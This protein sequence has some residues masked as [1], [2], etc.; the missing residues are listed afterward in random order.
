MWLI[1]KKE[2]LLNLLSF[3]FAT[4]FILCVILIP[5]SVHISIKH[6]EERRSIYSSER[7]E[8]AEQMRRL[9]TYSYIRPTIL[10]PP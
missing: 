4:G 1:A 5:L 2:F 3:R 9:Y 6:Y 10:R 8:C 7:E